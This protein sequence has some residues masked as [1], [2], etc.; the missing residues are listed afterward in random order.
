M[1]SPTPFERGVRKGCVNS[2]NRSKRGEELFLRSREES[3]RRQRATEQ[4]HALYLFLNVLLCDSFKVSIILVSL[5]FNLHIL[6]VF[7][8]LV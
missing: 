6:Q 8:A 1:P 5:Y 4:F 7:C 2:N 3:K